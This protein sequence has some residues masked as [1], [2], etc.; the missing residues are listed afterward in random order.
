MSRRILISVFILAICMA[1]FPAAGAHAASDQVLLVYS[2]R[3]KMTVI[4]D[5]IKA[6]DMTPVPVDSVEY[7]CEM[8][9]RYEYIVLQDAAPF[10]DALQTGKRFVCLG[11]G[12]QVVPGVQ[13][14]TVNRKINTQLRV[15]NNIQTAIIDQGLTYISEHSGEGVGSISFGG[16]EYPLGVIADRIMFAPYISRDDISVFAAAKML[17][18]Y[19]G[20]H[21]GGQMYIMI[22]EVYPFDDLDMLE[23]ITNRFYQ[24]GIP[25]VMSVMPV[26]YNT[27]YPSFK[28]YTN[29]LTY[30]QSRGTSFIMHEPIVREDELIL[31]D[32]HDRM[33]DAYK[34]YE[35]N[36]VHVYEE[37]IFPYAVSLDMLMRIQPVN[38]L[39][40]SLPIDTVIKFKVFEDEADLD[41]ALETINQKWLQIGDYRR[42]YTDTIDVYEE[43][44]IDTE[45]VY[46]Q[47][48]ESHY[49]FLVDK[50]NQILSIVVLISSVVI[51]ALI[52]LGYRLYRSKFIKR[53]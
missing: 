40:I 53:D 35:E 39:F 42:N 48:D 12:F 18:A 34:S 9:D 13:I 36:G 7:S 16:R 32:I 44:P 17:N 30:I 28:R 2:D 37:T 6:C 15:Y 47:K 8:M 4:A 23:T 22:D 19:F 1:I 3:E 27:D 41:A 25:V 38:E 21:D 26:H 10:K 20:R 14:D 52:V 33:A 50:G 45:Y 46:R 31:D 43:T 29:A 49:A 5:L 51:I 11:D 24:Y